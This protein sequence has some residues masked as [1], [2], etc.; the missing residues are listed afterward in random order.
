MRKGNALAVRVSLETGL[1]IGDVLALRPQDV[2]AD[3]SITCVCQK[4]RK[5]FRGTVGGRMV[6]ALTENSNY[7]WIFPSPRKPSAHR[8]RQAVWADVKRVVR[9]CGLAENVTPH[10]ARKIYAVGELRRCGLPTVQN[11]LQHEQISTTMIY[12]FADL[13][14]GKKPPFAPEKGA[15]EGQTPDIVEKFVEK[16]VENLGGIENVRKALRASLT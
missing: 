9:L 6:R 12:A 16:L 15:K 5:P 2:H 3:G 11:E 7:M 10:T 8:T 1:R 4:T 13:L 14:N